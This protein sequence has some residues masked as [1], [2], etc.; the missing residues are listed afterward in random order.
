MTTRLQSPHTAIA[1]VS[2]ILLANLLNSRA[3]F[4]GHTGMWG[5]GIWH[6]LLIGS[7]LLAALW[8]WFVAPLR[9]P[10]VATLGATLFDI[11]WHVTNSIDTAYLHLVNPG[12]LLLNMTLIT[13]IWQI[14]RLIR[15]NHPHTRASA[16]V[17]TVPTV[18]GWNIFVSH[19]PLTAVYAEIYG[20]GEALIGQGSSSLFIFV[21]MWSGV[22][23]WMRL[24]SIP[25]G[26]F[27]IITIILTFSQIAI[28][29]EWRFAIIMIGA[30]LIVE[31]SHARWPKHWHLNSVLW[32]ICFGGGYFATLSLTTTIAWETTVWSGIFII[33]MIISYA[34]AR[35]SNP[36]HRTTGAIG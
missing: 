27:T 18:L 31:I 16:L 21:A 23:T 26:T 13:T 2:T 36:Y 10:L 11:G 1:I 33:M 4:L 24:K 19:S 32:T 28:K 34:L 29:G 25:F 20:G 6:W 22:W 3:V 35:I 15:F 30:A 8:I 12:Y 14:G 7:G 17:M 5:I 9:W